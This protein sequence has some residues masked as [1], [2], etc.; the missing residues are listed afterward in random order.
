MHALIERPQTVKMLHDDISV[1]MG[2]NNN[3]AGDVFIEGNCLFRSN[4]DT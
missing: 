4:R 3:V 2:E 1:L